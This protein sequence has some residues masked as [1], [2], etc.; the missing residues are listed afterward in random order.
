[1]CFLQWVT[2][3][4]TA[5]VL[6]LL[7]IDLVLIL[8]NSGLC[9]PEPTRKK[10]RTSAIIL[11]ISRRSTAADVWNYVPDVTKDIAFKK[12]SVIRSP[13]C[14]CCC[15]SRMWFV[16]F[17]PFFFFF[18]APGFYPG[19]PKRKKCAQVRLS[20]ISHAAP[21]NVELSTRFLVQYRT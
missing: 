4:C 18:W 10:Q 3:T 14:H 16:L 7:D 13:S 9:T 15:C 12:E 2:G 5:L 21:A 8:V 17:F 19:R 6:L 11:F 1:M 20:F